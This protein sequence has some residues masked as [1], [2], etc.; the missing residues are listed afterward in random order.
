[1]GSGKRRGDM[2]GSHED[3]RAAQAEVEQARKEYDVLSRKVAADL[4]A[5]RLPSYEELLREEAARQRL[6]SATRRYRLAQSL[7]G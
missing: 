5:G 4:Q 2:A 6:L 3:W 1:M 7:R